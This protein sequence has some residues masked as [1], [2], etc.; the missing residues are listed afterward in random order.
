MNFVYALEKIPG[1]IVKY[2]ELTPKIKADVPQ[3]E[4]IISKPWGK[5]DELKQLKSDLAAL[6]PKK[7]EQDGEEVNRDDK[8]QQAH[9]VEA[10]AQSNGSKESMVA[11]PR[12]HYLSPPPTIRP[13]YRPAGL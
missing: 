9:Q 2:E 13:A 1:I 8:P 7:E 5:E 10:P 12:H 11:E 4:A 6:A 3:L